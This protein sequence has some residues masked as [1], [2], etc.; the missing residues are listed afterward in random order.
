MCSNRRSAPSRRLRSIMKQ[1]LGHAL[2]QIAFEKAGIIKPGMTIVC[3]ALPDVAMDV[4]KGVAADRGARIVEAATHAHVRSEMEEGRARVTIETR[5]GRYGPLLLALRGEHQVG[6]AV[7][8]VRR[9]RSG[10]REG[11]G[12]SG[13]RHHAWV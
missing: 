12:Y 3:G 9:A 10:A 8:A 5:S 11:A 4:V 1:H 7:V 2:E 6:N 13:S